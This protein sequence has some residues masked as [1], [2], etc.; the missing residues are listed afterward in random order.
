MAYRGPQEEVQRMAVEG[1]NKGN[2]GGAYN[3]AS[4][5][6]NNGQVPYQ[7]NQATTGPSYAQRR[8]MAA[9]QL[10]QNPAYPPTR[11]TP[12]TVNSD[13]TVTNSGLQNFDLPFHHGTG[14]TYTG[15][16]QGTF[17]PRAYLAN[18][19]GINASQ[20]GAQQPQTGLPSTSPGNQGGQFDLMS[21]LSQMF[22]NV[23]GVTPGMGMQGKQ[24]SPFARL[25]GSMTDRL[26]STT[27][28]QEIPMPKPTPTEPTLPVS[29]SF[30][31]Q[32]TGG[33]RFGPGVGP[34]T[35]FNLPGVVQDYLDQQ[36][37][38]RGTMPIIPDLQ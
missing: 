32:G 7:L 21:A 23:G 22:G 26:R 12:P 11:Y 18:L 6:Y 25:F 9:S 4:P 30:N 34:G 14:G 38:L 3:M 13:G 27:P 24:E 17:D 8:D 29:P 28:V 19:F 1:P 37:L 33:G 15:G 16:M 36:N 35:G 20:P 31:P 10:Q 2:P 5:N